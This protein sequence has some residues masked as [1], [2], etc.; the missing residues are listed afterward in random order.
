MCQPSLFLVFPPGQSIGNRSF[1]KIKIKP[2]NFLAQGRQEIILLCL[3]S[4]EPPQSREVLW[5]ARV[6][7]RS[8]FGGGN[9]ISKLKIQKN[10]TLGTL[11]TPRA[12]Q[13]HEITVG[14]KT[15]QEQLYQCCVRNLQTAPTDLFCF[16]NSHWTH[17]QI[18]KNLK[19]NKENISL[20]HPSPFLIFQYPNTAD[21]KDVMSYKNKNK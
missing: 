4:S 11:S 17:Q 20:P 8:L 1:W 18:T 5:M 6:E 21:K 19:G 10:C 3:N 9:I 2:N 12:Q 15:E 16:L 7:Q 13:C 14:L